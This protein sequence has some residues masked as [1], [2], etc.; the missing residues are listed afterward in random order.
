AREFNRM[1]RQ[2]LADPKI[3]RRAI[4]KANR[5]L[6]DYL[7]MSTFERE[8][9]RRLIPFYGWI[10]AITTIAKNTA[11]ETPG[12]ADLLAKLGEI[13]VTDTRKKLGPLPRFLEGAIPAPWLH[14]QPGRVPIISTSGLNP[15]ATVPQVFT[16][17]GALVHGKPGATGRALGPQL[18]PFA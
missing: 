17:A 18:N 2:L 6:G 8:S 14:A 12:R 13:G 10:R 3:A 9:V 5:T 11:V 7:S 1:A 16:A 4:D 15:F